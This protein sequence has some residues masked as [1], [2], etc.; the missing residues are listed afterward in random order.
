M[1]LYEGADPATH[2]R[3]VYLYT[4]T[5]GWTRRHEIIE[6]VMIPFDCDSQGRL[7]AVC[8]PFVA[9]PAVSAGDDLTRLPAA[10]AVNAPARA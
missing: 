10:G 7:C 9:L 3:G 1:H 6:L 4:E 2:K 8:E 5:T